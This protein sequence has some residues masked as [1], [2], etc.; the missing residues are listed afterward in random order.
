MYIPPINKATDIEETIAF[1]KQFSFATIITA[2]DNLPEATHLPFIVTVKND[3]IIL[4]SHF[5]KANRQ[6]ENIETEKVLVIFTEPHAYISPS[7][8]EKELNVPTW[9]YI[10]IHAYG[11]G[12]IITDTATTLT[13]LEATIDNYEKP[14]RQQ[15]NNFPI[16][17]KVKMANGIVAF[18]MVVTDLQ[19][20]KK[21]SQ[22][23]TTIEKENIIQHLS[24][25]TVTN[26][27]LIADFMKREQIKSGAANE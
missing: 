20:K 12:K 27:I 7:N 1:M 14:Y 6:W 23:R 5:A 16:D 10:A 17:Y 15:W 19:A 3:K 25:S 21:L 24:A 4:T 26:E 9:N 8:Y 22:N 13:I 2:K 11:Q 18:E